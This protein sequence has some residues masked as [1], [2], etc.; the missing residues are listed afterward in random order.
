M[1][2]LSK[3]RRMK[4]GAIRRRLRGS[5]NPRTFK[6]FKRRGGYVRKHYKR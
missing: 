5:Y 1:S 3:R 4:R 2:V 6:R